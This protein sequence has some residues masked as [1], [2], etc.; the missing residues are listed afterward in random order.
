MWWS[1]TDSGCARGGI[2]YVVIAIIPS[3]IATQSQSLQPG[4]RAGQMKM[5]E[6][7]NDDDIEARW[8]DVVREKTEEGERS[9]QGRR[10]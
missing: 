7:N 3:G 10:P 2:R 9:K 6:K 1:R 8:M 5:I 4:R